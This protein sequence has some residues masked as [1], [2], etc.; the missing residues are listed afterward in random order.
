MDLADRGR[1]ERTLVEVAEH[2]LQ[3]RAELLPHQLLQVREPHRRDVVAERGQAALQLV[4]LLFRETVELDH[5]DHLADLH[6][7]AAHLPKLF[8]ELLDQR[9]GPLALGRRGALRRPDP[10]GGSHPGPPQALPRHQPTDTRSP[11]EPTGWQPA[12]LGQLIV[13]PRTH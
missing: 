1:G 3:R 11:R 10:V 7:R 6:R 12:R 8:D 2:V 9:G 5:R 13:G 4:P